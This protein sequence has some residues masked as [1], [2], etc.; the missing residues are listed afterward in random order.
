MPV[1]IGMGQGSRE[2]GNSLDA[3]RRR[4]GGNPAL[5]N[6]VPSGTSKKCWSPVHWVRQ[7]RRDNVQTDSSHNVVKSRPRKIKISALAGTRYWDN[8][9]ALPFGRDYCKVTTDKKLSF[10][11]VF[12]LLSSPSFISSS[13]LFACFVFFF[14]YHFLSLLF[15]YMFSLLL[16][17]SCTS[18]FFYCLFLSFSLVSPLLCSI[19]FL[20]CFVSSLFS[21]LFLLLFSPTSFLFFCHLSP[22]LFFSLIIRCSVFY[23]SLSALPFSVYSNIFS[24]FILFWFTSA[25][26]GG[27]KI[28][29]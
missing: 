8:P 21:L 7:A 6:A 28:R 10:L 13:S 18:S 25:Y 1:G 16:S 23:F 11:L 5:G 2:L 27:S 3:R 17:P 12:S 15:F 20:F 29:F 22:R 9:F 14:F 26:I 19:L 4:V 24:K